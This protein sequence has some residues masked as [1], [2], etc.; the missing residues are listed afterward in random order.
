MLTESVLIFQ[1]ALLNVVESRQ[2]LLGW[3]HP[4]CCTLVTLLGH[5]M[6]TCPPELMKIPFLPYP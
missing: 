1:A 6:A 3:H 4:F 2:L 5:G